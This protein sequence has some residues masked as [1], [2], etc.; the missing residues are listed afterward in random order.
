MN[1]VIHTERP[2][3]RPTPEMIE[4]ATRRNG[5]PCSI[6]SQ[7]CGDPAPGQ[8]ALDKRKSR[9]LADKTRGFWDYRMDTIR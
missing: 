4:E 5:A 2:A 7:V 8:S 1:N 6:T 3:N 9:I